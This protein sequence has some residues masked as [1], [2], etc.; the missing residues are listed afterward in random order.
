MNRNAEALLD[1]NTNYFKIYTL[2][3]RNLTDDELN[4]WANIG[5]GDEVILHQLDEIG[6]STTTGTICEVRH[7]RWDVAAPPATSSTLTLQVTPHPNTPPDTGDDTVAMALW[8]ATIDWGH[9]PTADESGWDTLGTTYGDIDS[10]DIDT[11]GDGTDDVELDAIKRLSDGRIRI[12]ANSTAEYNRLEG[13]FM[14]LRN[15]ATFPIWLAIPTSDNQRGTTVA[16]IPESEDPAEDHPVPVSIWDTLPPGA[17]LTPALVALPAVVG[18]AQDTAVAALTNFNVVVQTMETATV[19]QIGNVISQSPTQGTLVRPGSEV[20]LTVG[21]AEV[22]QMVAVPDVTN[23]TEGDAR[24]DIEDVGL[25]ATFEDRDELTGTDDLVIETIPAAGTQVAVGSTVR[26]VLRNLQALVPDVRGETRA[27][28][29]RLL[30]EADFVVGADLPDQDTD[31]GTNDNLV[32]RTQPAPGAQVDDGSTVRHRPVELRAGG[33]RRPRS[34]TWTATR[35]PRPTPPLTAANL[36]GSQGA[37]IDTL[38]QGDNDRVVAQSPA[39]GTTVNEGSTVTFQLGNYIGVTVPDLIGDDISDVVTEIAGLNLV[40]SQSRRGRERRG[41]RR[42]GADP[43][44]RGQH[45]RRPRLDGHGDGGQLRG[46]AGADGAVVRHPHRHHRRL[47]VGLRQ[48]SRGQRRLHSVGHGGR[49][50]RRRRRQRRGRD[51]H[52][53]RHQ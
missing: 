31:V 16:L 14:R 53:H 18:S 48:P 37:D 22:I 1:A 26:V 6:H 8:T 44:T 15:I 42:Q 39:A 20:T 46:S 49:G 34:P 36:V 35:W 33:G 21:I 43:D 13:K 25:V 23:H 45:H 9:H 12:E 38:V 11:D 5:L 29:V 3:L 2:T 50:H 28:A 51:D 32:S 41:P 30:E 7:L 52:P 27:E 17:S 40:L 47:L 10:R 24:T 19:S 4:L